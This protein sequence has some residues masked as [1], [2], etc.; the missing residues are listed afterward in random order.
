[1]FDNF[2]KQMTAR[3]TGTEQLIKDTAKRVFFAEGKL[4][5]TT[6]DIADAAGIS[7]TSLHYY[8]RSRDELMKQVFNEAVTALND[9]L[10]NLMASD[11]SFREKIE[12]MVNL[13]LTESM[14]FPYKGTFLITEMLANDKDLYKMKEQGYPHIKTFLKEVGREMKAGNISKM[15]PV[16]FMMN[17]FALTS[18]PLLMRPLHKALL[19]LTDEQ[20]TRLMN[21]RKKLVVDILFR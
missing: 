5:A 20:Y 2:V 13:F 3:E 19:N 18:Y 11:L 21:E 10:Y 12:K 1:M 4:H 7:R 16:Q 15:N 17:M 9:K 6:Q 14:E 8:Y